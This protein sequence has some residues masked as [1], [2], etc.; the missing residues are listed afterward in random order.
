MSAKKL[1]RRRKPR[2][3][4]VVQPELH[5]SSV[6]NYSDTETT[7]CSSFGDEAMGGGGRL[8]AH[9][10]HFASNFAASILFHSYLAFSPPL[11]DS[12]LRTSHVYA[13]WSPTAQ[14]VVIV[15]TVTALW[16]EFLDSGYIV[17]ATAALI[18][19]KQEEQFRELC[20]SHINTASKLRWILD[21]IS[22]L[23]GAFTV[24]LVTA[25]FSPVQPFGSVLPLPQEVFRELTKGPGDPP[26]LS[27]D[28]L[29]LATTDNTRAAIATSLK[30]A[31]HMAVHS[32]PTLLMP[33]MYDMHHTVQ[34]ISAAE[35]LRACSLLFDL[36]LVQFLSC[37]TLN[38]VNA[39]VKSCSFYFELK[40]AGRIALAVLLLTIATALPYC[41]LVGGPMLGM[42]YCALAAGARLDPWC[43]LLTA[44]ADLLA[45]LCATRIVQPVPIALAGM[46]KQNLKTK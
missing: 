9:A 3:S 39:L 2:G 20:G 34:T 43:F 23:L 46:H 35:L 7:A 31:V 44:S 45:T 16:M 1:N 19:L 24:G 26:S 10:T 41:G 13:K 12:L 6:T 40:H 18:G 11:L 42:S 22:G 21:G 32:C 38:S 28:L 14:T 17:D 33:V 4:P 5:A 27:A 29:R 25:L 30:F 36:F 37:L 15:F 8:A